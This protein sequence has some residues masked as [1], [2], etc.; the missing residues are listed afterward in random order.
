MKILVLEPLSEAQ[1]AR[2]RAAAGL[3]GVVPV[4][5]GEG[6]AAAL[7][8]AD[9]IFGAVGRDAFPTARRLRWI[10]VPLT[11][12]DGHLFPALIASD[13]ALT[14]TKDCVGTHLAEQAFGLLLALTRSIAAAAREPRWHVRLTLRANARRRRDAARE[15]QE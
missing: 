5:A 10:H 4:P 7:A 8:Q 14:S 13:V 3:A 6:S 1:L 12:V 15:G 11:F 9:V 2:V